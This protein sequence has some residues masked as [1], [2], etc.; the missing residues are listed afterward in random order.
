M[1][2]VVTENLTGFENL[3]GLVLSEVLLLIVSREIKNYEF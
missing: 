1:L 3:I 2:D